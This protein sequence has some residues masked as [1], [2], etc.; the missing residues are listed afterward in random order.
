M[1]LC[2]SKA[3]RSTAY[4]IDRLMLLKKCVWLTSCPLIV[5]TLFSFSV[6]S[7]VTLLFLYY[8]CKTLWTLKQVNAFF[9]RLDAGLD[10]TLITPQKYLQVQF[11]EVFSNLHHS[12]IHSYV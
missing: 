4:M 1:L 2:N 3:I 12:C 11:C 6:L 7:R 8:Y 10:L 5:S 9:L